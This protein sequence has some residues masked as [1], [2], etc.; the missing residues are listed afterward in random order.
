M[1]KVLIFSLAYY[2][3]HVGGA[4]VAIKEITDRIDERDIEFHMV[5]L[6][7]DSTLPKVEKVGNVLVHRIG[8]T[9]KNPQMADLRS[10]PLHLNK[11]LFQF[12]AAWKASRLHKKY[13]YDAV[14]AMM[15]HS[16]G[17]PAGIF[18]TFNTNIPYILTLQEGDPPEYIE[19]KMALIKPLFRRGFTKADIIQTIST[20]LSKWARDM[21]FN[22]PIEIIPNA[23]NTSH[24][25]Q[26]YSEEDIKTVKSEIGKKEKDV[27]IVTTSRLVH[28]NAVDDVISALPK[29]PKN[30]KFLIFGTGPDEKTLRALAKKEEVEKR[31]IFYGQIDRN[32]MPKYLKA[33]DIFIRPSRSE[34]MGISFVEA[35]AAE[36]P[37][38]A[39]Q[40]GGISDFLFDEKRNPDKEATGWAVDKD[41]PEQI[42]DAVQD[43]IDH[44]ENVAKVIKNAKE[45]AFSKYD[46]NIIAKDMKTKVFNKVFK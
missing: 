15:A 35:F 32:V 14:W 36:L 37:V 13:K 27:Y 25:S 9:T 20:F 6:R 38:I 30:V 16:C 18:K 24:F 19:R 39:T 42:R 34:G 2:P 8:F 1:K 7:F 10:F 31:V 11:I 12:L 5:T 28:K 23:V 21:E 22:G 4:E 40:E 33:C 17:V 45:L 26:N 44:P 41:S 3:K 46:W 29:L 43:I